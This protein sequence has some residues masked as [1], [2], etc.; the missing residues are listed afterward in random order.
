LEKIT[1]LEAGALEML[2]EIDMKTD[3]P[4]RKK[5]CSPSPFLS[6]LSRG[7][8]RKPGTVKRRVRFHLAFLITLGGAFAQALT[9]GTTKFSPSPQLLTSTRRSRFWCNS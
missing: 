4:G 9:A 3:L 1:V 2:F 7:H 8:K 5:K 6:Q